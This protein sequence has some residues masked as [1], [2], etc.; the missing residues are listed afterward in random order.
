MTD[1]IPQSICIVII[2]NL[3]P[4][5]AEQLEEWE[6]F[7]LSSTFCRLPWPKFDWKSIDPTK[8]LL[9]RRFSDSPFVES[10]ASGFE[11]DQWLPKNN[12]GSYT[13]I[14]LLRHWNQQILNQHLLSEPR[15]SG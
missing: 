9:E 4:A 5:L 11:D 6:S 2:T 10:V 14:N 8:G 3:E 7:E 12:A 1:S 13:P 15:G